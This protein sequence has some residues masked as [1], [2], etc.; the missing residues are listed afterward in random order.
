VRRGAT[1]RT[2][3]DART[4]RVRRPS[5]L[6]HPPSLSH[7]VAPTQSGPPGR[8]KNLGKGWEIFKIGVLP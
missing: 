1:G 6:S 2:P 7:P 8:T 5:H 4:H 3:G